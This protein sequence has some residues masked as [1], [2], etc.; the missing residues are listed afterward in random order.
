MVNQTVNKKLGIVALLVFSLTLL[1]IFIV[2][3]F[4]RPTQA[5]NTIW[6]YHIVY[7]TLIA[8]SPIIA[9][10]LTKS[11]IPLTTYILFFFGVED[12]L[13]YALQGYLPETYWGVS[14][15]GIWQPAASTVLVLNIVGLGVT[16]LYVGFLV[17]V[18]NLR[19]RMH[20][21]I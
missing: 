18:R 9:A 17:Y 3:T 7:W 4:Y 2:E 12:T 15:A 20:C 1:D 5:W 14:I 10:Y 8:A 19:E 16:T 11:L 21:T 6:Q 13:F